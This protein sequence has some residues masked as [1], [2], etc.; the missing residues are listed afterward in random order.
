M[1]WIDNI[2]WIENIQLYKKYYS[3]VKGMELRILSGAGC[4]GACL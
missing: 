2:Q 4:G 1:G 3:T